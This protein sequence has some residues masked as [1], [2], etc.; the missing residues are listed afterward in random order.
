MLQ[1][2]RDSSCFLLFPLVLNPVLTLPAGLQD[3]LLLP[4]RVSFVISKYDLIV[5][6]PKM[7]WRQK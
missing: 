1:G 4:N 7:H 6:P 5:S 3:K 2:Q